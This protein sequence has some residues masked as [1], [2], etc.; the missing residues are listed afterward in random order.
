MLKRIIDY[1]LDH[2]WIVVFGLITLIA[3]GLQA[4]RTLPIDAFPD[5]TNNQ[6]TVITEAPGLAPVEVEQLV[7]FPI[8]SAMM[9]LPD[10]EEVRS[11]SKF[12]LSIVTIVFADSVD[13]Y[14]ARQLV[15]ERLIEARNRI[16]QG[17]EPQMGPVATAFGEVYQYTLE[18]EGYSAMELKTLH[19]WDVKYQLRAVP[20]VADVNTWGGLSQQFEI[21]I[22]PH[23]LQSYGLTL[24]DVFE[25]VRDNNT[26]F[27]GGFVEHGS[28]QYTVR[29]LGRV[30]DM[31]EIES[32][33]L[34][35]HRGIPIAI[36]DVAEVRIGSMPRQGAVT[37]DGDGERVSGMVIMLK[38]QNSK[39]VIERVKVALENMRASLPE[40]VSVE[41]FY[42]QAD[43]IDGTIRTVRDNLL[44]GGALVAL[45][46]YLFLGKA[47]A[48]LIVAAVIPLSM[49][50]AFLGM[51]AFGISA[52]LM[53]LGAVDFGMVV[54]GSVIM[55]ENCVR[56][57]RNHR[58]N[59][60]NSSISRFDEI[61][62]AAHEVARP[63]LMGVAI[64]IAVYVPLLTLQDLEGRMF[65][66]MAVTVCSALLGSLAVTLLVVP[67][68]SWLLLRD[69]KE[70]PEPIL[71]RIRGVYTRL[72]ESLLKRPVLVVAPALLLVV[73]AISSLGLIGTEFMPRL[74]EGSILIQTFK[75]PSI[76]LTESAHIGLDVE[77]T[78]KRLPE[79]TSVVTKIG[80]PDLAIEAMG[81]YESDVYVILKP[82]DEWTTA[83][84]KEGL[85]EAMSKEL[86]SIPGVV[87]NFTQPMAMRLDETISGIK[88]DVAVKIFGEEEAVLD[89]TAD[90]VL[91]VLARV[92]GAADARKQI[93]SGAAEWQVD[94]KRAELARYGLNVTDVRDLVQSAIAGKPVTELV[95]GRRRFPIAV[96]LPEAYR[97]NHEKLGELLLRAPDGEQVPLARVADIRPATGPEVVEREDSQRRIVVQSNVRGRDLGSFVA[98]AQRRIEAEV[99]LPTGYFIRWGGQ[100]ENQE[101]AMKRFAL[102]IPAVLALIFFLLFSAFGSM[103]QSLLVLMIV[104]FAT[105]GGI[106]ALWLRGMNLN[107]SASIGFIAVFGVAIL[108][109]VVLVSTT[110]T[111][112]AEGRAVKQAVV[113]AASMRLRPV[114]MTSVVA[115]LGFLPMAIAT[116][117]GAEVQRPLATVVIGGLVSSTLLTLLLLPLMFPWFRGTPAVNQD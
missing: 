61:R 1:P 20:G 39:T 4:L 27:G 2:P 84:T 38:G 102:V 17:I 75:L 42:D 56:R 73:A 35:S 13:T 89:R 108:D 109:G 33:V 103:R 100:F 99:K 29:G 76:S 21:V 112:L 72:L 44:K 96:R 5:L 37:R 104:P 58:G 36:R 30:A 110:N 111:L 64:I 34:D 50:V 83:S 66:P 55:V 49:L 63:I 47:R 70:A 80:R 86:S 62:S 40:G 93:F 28:E 106:G 43:V 71:D 95:E 60:S 24:R 68:A 67:A 9:G 82:R 51:Q 12:S 59:P 81:I 98:E 65:R 32:I 14:F 18:G 6:V 53:S 15:N 90:Q 101:R 19:D 46:L 57:L 16:P 113:E 105:V 25:R 97:G 115:A 88:A 11:I 69:V 22:D 48:A 23:R 8:E 52:N 26:N 85:I 114:I 54:D 10:T 107:V 77:R 87:Y 92:P 41:P 117:I 74:D 79:V 7:T 31:Q 91:R 116:S 45:V 94:I 78:L 3:A